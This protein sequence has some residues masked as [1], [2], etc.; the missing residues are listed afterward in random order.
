MITIITELSIERNHRNGERSS[1][2]RQSSLTH[3]LKPSL[4]AST[5]PVDCEILRNSCPLKL[6]SF[7]EC[8]GEGVLRHFFKRSPG[9]ETTDGTPEKTETFRLK[10]GRHFFALH[11]AR[12]RSPRRQQHDTHAQVA[13]RRQGTDERQRERENLIER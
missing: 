13:P 5:P 8:P 2:R 9:A 7:T 12:A 6:T 11:Y 1:F 4:L 10:R 3:S